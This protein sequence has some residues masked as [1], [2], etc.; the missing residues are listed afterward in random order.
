MIF[1][2]I[3]GYQVRHHWQWSLYFRRHKFPTTCTM[4]PI[5]TMPFQTLSNIFLL[6][7]ITSATVRGHGVSI[8][9]RQNSSSTACQ[10][11]V[12]FIYLD[13]FSC[14]SNIFQCETLLDNSGID[15]HFPGNGNFTVWDAKQQEVVSACRVMPTS[16]DDVVRIMSALTENW[17][18]FA[19]KGGGHARNADDSVSVGG[20]T[21]DMVRMKSMEVASNRTLAKIGSG[22][23]LYS[24][25]TG[26]EAYNLTTVGGR[27]GGVGIGGYALGGGFSNWSPKF[28][29]GMDNIFEYSVY[30]YSTNRS[31]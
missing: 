16:T 11:A 2:C 29:L 1:S 4:F 6:F 21:I 20:V 10:T 7:L 28:G 14:V 26:L 17:C 31:M 3:Y 22:H 19:V 27:S 8:E 25:Y 23:T 18:N 13:T 24:L 30:R 9:R 15:V 12:L 5:R